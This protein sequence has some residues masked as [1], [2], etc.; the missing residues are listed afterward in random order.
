MSHDQRSIRAMRKQMDAALG[1]P[2]KPA[3][4]PSNTYEP[5]IPAQEAHASK[6]KQAG[7]LVIRAAVFETEAEGQCEI[8]E[9]AGLDVA[10]AGC[11][12]RLH[13]CREARRE[14]VGNLETTQ[15]AYEEALRSLSVEGE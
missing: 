13:K 8:A 7:E 15:D 12:E 2:E 4:E 1:I 3:V 10:L 5:M 11:H 9:R 6:I 14:A